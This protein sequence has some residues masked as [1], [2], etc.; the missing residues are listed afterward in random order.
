MTYQKEGKY[1]LEIRTEEFAVKVLFFSKKI[2]RIPTYYKVTPQLVAA[3]SSVGA[4]YCEATE[5]ES[6]NDFRH[7]ISI[8]NKEAKESKYWLKILIRSEETLRTEA[9]QLWNE[10]NELHRIFS[11]IVRTCRKT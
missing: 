11:Q 4:N 10:A 9:L 7:K 6:S 2:P 8:C 5:A 1:N 3:A